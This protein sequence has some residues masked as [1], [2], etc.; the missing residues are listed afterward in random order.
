M[1]KSQTT[2]TWCTR[3]LG[4]LSLSG[5]LVLA[6]A[7]A[8]PSGGA[9]TKSATSLLA[10]ALADAR[11][12][13][14]VY[15]N[16]E[17]KEGGVAVESSHDHI[18]AS[19][20]EQSSILSNG[21]TSELIAVNG[22]QTLYLRADAAALTLTYSMSSADAATYA[23]EWLELTPSTPIYPSVAYATTLASDFSQVRFIGPLHL[24]GPGAVDGKNVG[25]IA[26]DVPAVNGAPRFK[27][28]LDVTTHGRVLPVRF[29]EVRGSTTITVTWS[30]WG[31]AAA[32]AVPSG[33]VAYPSS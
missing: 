7:V 10:R 20:G 2:T 32:L 6:G 8:A 27:G 12:S 17:I 16:V 23:N 18:G 33:A 13:H 14:W 4:A 11:S 25:V 29:N 19:S 31:R 9:A 5:V 26:S 22:A 24:G 15:E 21:G 28:T 1:K 3:T 30:K